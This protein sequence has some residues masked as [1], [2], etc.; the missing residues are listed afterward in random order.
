MDCAKLV[1]NNFSSRKQ[2]KLLH[3][4]K[5]A[6][7]LRVMRQGDKIVKS[8]FVLYACIGDNNLSYQK[9]IRVGFTCSKKLGNAVIRNRAKRRLRALADEYLPHLGYLG[10][11]YV[12]IGRFSTTCSMP[13]GK[14]KTELANAITKL[15]HRYEKRGHLSE[16]VA[17]IDK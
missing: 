14:M 4:K 3:L 11:D 6:H 16:H 17:V 1:K 13:F 15:H 9:E 8:G 7:F 2:K 12:L 5:R 10:W